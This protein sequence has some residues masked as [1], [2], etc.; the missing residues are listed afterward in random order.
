MNPRAMTAAH[1]TRSFG[2]RVTVT[3]LGTGRSI[4]VRIKRPWPV[5][6]WPL[7][8]PQLWRCKGARHGRDGGVSVDARQ[9]GDEHHRKIESMAKKIDMQSE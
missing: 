1:K 7:H 4:T 8:R 9:L 5:H 6:P 3:H 2:S